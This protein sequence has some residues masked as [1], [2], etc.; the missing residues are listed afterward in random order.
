[1][2]SEILFFDFSILTEFS[3]D[4]NRK[5]MGKGIEIEI[6]FLYYLPQ[7]VLLQSSIQP[8]SQSIKKL[9]HQ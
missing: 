2:V 4:F 9:Q 3:P 6:P 7:S 1:M 5:M 8:F